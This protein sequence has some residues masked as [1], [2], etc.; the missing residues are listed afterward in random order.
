MQL[1]DL[2]VWLLLKEDLIYCNGSLQ[3]I[4]NSF[5][6]LLEGESFFLDFYCSQHLLLL[7]LFKESRPENMIFLIERKKKMPKKLLALLKDEATKNWQSYWKSLK[8]FFL[9]CA[10]INF[11]KC[12]AILLLPATSLSNLF[13]NVLQKSQFSSFV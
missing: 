12:F 8:P 10:L 4:K 2:K 13:S 11:V 9:H 3:A 5:T 6:S 1:N 7:L